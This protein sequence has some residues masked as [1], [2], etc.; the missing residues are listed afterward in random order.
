MKRTML[1]TIDYP[2]MFGGVANYWA[3]LNKNLPGQD[4]VVL[5]PEADDSLDFDQHQNYIIYRK[6]LMNKWCAFCPEWL[7]ILRE[8]YRLIKMEKIQKLIVTHV[9]PVGTVALIL[10]KLFNIPYIVSFH[11]LD[12]ALAGVTKRKFWLTKKIIKNAESIV[13]NSQSTLNILKKIDPQ[14]AEKTEI[15]YPCANIQYEKVTEGRLQN[16]R[17]L[18]NLHGKSLILCVGRFIKRKGQDKLIAAMEKVVE[19]VPNAYCIL[20]GQGPEQDSLQ[21]LVGSYG[22]EDHVIIFDDILDFE[23]PVLYESCE[24]FVMPSRILKN[25][26][27]E[28]FGIVYLE[29]NLYGKPVVAGNEGGATEAVADRKSGILVDPHNPTEIADALIILLSDKEKAEE[30]GEYG[31]SRAMEKFTWEKQAEKLVRLIDK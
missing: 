16:F 18:F 28:G 11:G 27:I 25:G 10:K 30:M 3:N 20:V 21:R 17:N 7:P 31:K 29:A 9:L 19:K 12:A 1:V 14:V 6:N 8:T 15:I 2:P 24:V 4:L 26:D 13:S 22:L 23:L 5:A